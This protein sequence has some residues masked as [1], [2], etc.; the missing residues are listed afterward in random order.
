MLLGVAEVSFL[1]GVLFEEGR[2]AVGYP[3]FGADYSVLGF[4]VLLLGRGG[5]SGGWVW[6]GGC[7]FVIL[8]WCD[9]ER[10]QEEKYS[11]Q[12]HNSTAVSCHVN[13]LVVGK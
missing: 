2:P 13:K 12:K 5:W 4:S 10:E 8:E 7:V 1:V 3:G 9:E 6:G 11:Q